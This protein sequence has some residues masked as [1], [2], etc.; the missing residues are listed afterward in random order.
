MQPPVLLTH[1]A[2]IEAASQAVASATTAAPASLLIS[3]LDHFQ[4]LI[5][6]TGIDP[7]QATL[8]TVFELVRR[9]LRNGD[10]VARAGGDELL[11]LLRTNPAEALHVAERLCAAV[12]AHAFE[13]SGTRHVSIS[14]GVAGVPEHATTYAALHSAA[15]AARIRIKAQGRD[16]AAV[17][18][19]AHHETLHRP[20]QID[21]FAG[22]ADELRTLGGWLREAVRG[23]PRVVAVV[24]ETGTGTGM[25]LR[26]LEPEIRLHGGVFVEG[27]A[28]R[29]PVREAYGVWSAALESLR[30]LPNAP[31]REWRELSKLL[32]SL[33]ANVGEDADTRP[34]SK[35][36]LHE[37][38]IEHLRLSAEQ[39]P[40]V[41]VLDEMQWAD[42]ES[43]EALD[44]VVD[45]LDTERVLL[46][47]SM[48]TEPA[49]AEAGERRRRL[50]RHDIFHEL[51]LSRLTRDD[52]KRWLEAAFH[53]QD[54]G[55]E[56]LAFL[57]R[58]SEGNPLFIAELLRTLSE[59]GALWHNGERWEWSPVSELRL[60]T[61]LNALIA[62]RLQRFP[63]ST[64][65]VLSTAA[66]IGHEFDVGLVVAAGAGS[67]GAV[68]LALSEALEAGIIRRTLERAGGRF[69]FSHSIVA[70]ALIEMVLPDQLRQLH[71]RV[72]AALEK[73][74]AHRVAEIASHYDLAGS[75]ASAYTFALSAATRS[76]V[77]NAE[78]AAGDFLRLASRNAVTPGDLAEV[79]IR[80]ANL[81]EAAGRY[82]EVEELCDLAIEWFASQGDK[83]RALVLRRMRERA[84]REL[85]QPA[86][87]TL[88][89]LLALDHEA[90]EPGFVSE[91][92]SI[93]MMLSQTYARVGDPEAEERIATEC[94][95]MAETL[96]DPTLL[97]QALQ[98]LAASVHSNVSKSSESFARARALY[99]RV[100]ELFQQTG[101]VRGQASV[102]NNIGIV[103]LSESKWD[104]AR[105]A[106][107]SAT[108]LARL[109]GA[110]E[111]WARAAINLGVMT[112]RI[113]EFDRARELFGE[114]LALFAAIKN[115]H[116]QVMAVYNM[117]D[118]ERESGDL[119]AAVELF[120]ATISLAKRIG[121]NEIE[122]GATAAAGLC[123][124]E[125]GRTEDAR[126]A[127]AEVEERMR[128]RTGWFQG[129]DLVEALRVRM[130][131]LDGDLAGAISRFEEVMPLADASDLYTA[132]WLTA[133]C[134]PSLFDV[135][136][137]LMKKWIRKYADRVE[138]LG[139]GHMCKQ[140]LD[141]LAR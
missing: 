114:A 60:P 14:I 43:W 99:R 112:Q 31:V 63:T 101:D 45:Q 33:G 2:F 71:G 72:A 44:H 108:A 16:G 86:R 26:Q 19:P 65:A 36:L 105:E 29:T 104:E 28:L 74:A 107:S 23:Q 76:E 94:V 121:A 88:E 64:L 47:L 39:Q 130:S 126:A 110:P 9:N 49:F 89:A 61:G 1:D 102:L 73:R 109:V 32:P 79:R 106:L 111:L 30:R 115:S 4:R 124:L 34:G 8:E 57:Y 56:F 82:D 96:G 48:R 59:E 67:E 66:I 54:I 35:Y 50:A 24:G 129:R 68:Q 7:A 87:V 131:L 3:D 140:Y 77:L 103:A 27:R 15:D 17:A 25:L 98:R 83:R 6:G 122:I 80:L 69:A 46:C 100:L 141:L 78:T 119:S 127:A 133:A 123:Y 92:I 118:L 97:A 52:V 134:A 38:L 93:M 138:S 18:A 22:R 136:P 12:R 116:G 51:Q 37:E 62:R 117:A 120:E 11:V 40:V 139:Y 128:A 42:E 41:I 58:H 90:Q 135:D 137:I 81:A 5:D 132:A 70:D 84:R 13:A 125:S 85:G 75:Q 95:R 53:H 91:R 113:G 21:R 55:R 10:L 20:L